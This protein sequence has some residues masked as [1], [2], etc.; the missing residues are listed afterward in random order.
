MLKIFFGNAQDNNFDGYKTATEVW[1]EAT[2]NAEY[3]LIQ[4]PW[5]IP[6]Q[7]V[8]AIKLE[9]TLEQ[10]SNPKEWL[11]IIQEVYRVC[12]DGAL[13]E[14]KSH[15]L[16]FFKTLALPF[17]EKFFGDNRSKFLDSDYRQQVLEQWLE[18]AELLRSFPTN[19][20]EFTIHVNLIVEPQK[21]IPNLN[22]L[23]S[24]Q[25]NALLLQHPEVIESCTA[26]WCAIHDPMR[27]FALAKV[28][29][30]DN[31]TLQIYPLD[32]EHDMWVS[33]LLLK[34]NIWEPNETY[35]FLA[36]LE[37]FLNLYQDQ[38]LHVAN[39]GANIG[40]YTIVAAK[41]NKHVH[42]DAFEPTPDTVKML[43]YNVEHNNLNEQVTIYNS[44]LSDCVGE[45]EFFVNSNDAGSN[46]LV[47]NSKDWRESE[48]NFSQLSTKIKTNTLDNLY[49][50]KAPQTWPKIVLM[51]VEGHEQKVFDG[52]QGLFAKGFRPVLFTEFSPLLMRLRGTCTYYQDLV[53]KYEYKPYLLISEPNQKTSK[54]LV[55]NLDNLD[56]RY[57]EL[58]N[59]ETNKQGL[60][61]N[62][63][64]VP[65]DIDAS[66]IKTIV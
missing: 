35:L 5:P 40:W 26:S 30:M 20:K 51:D 57:E 32:G 7:S 49:L 1:Q 48:N 22:E 43:A 10:Q 21:L 52:A 11:N 28:E 18:Q 45:S 64:F 59:P 13:V 24:D 3:N 16:S 42:V 23:S 46:S 58:Q 65:K 19:F 27:H 39:I 34:N 66:Q 4:M 41:W 33:R 56:Q 53:E 14:V 47:D 50:E 29:R 62:V 9:W 36:V 15:T 44:A 17:E 54:L 60:F 25:I 31:F 61:L 37:H 8:S 55:T 38:P 2:G 6:D 12:A 63:L